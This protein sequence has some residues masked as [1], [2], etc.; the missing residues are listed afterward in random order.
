MRMSSG[1]A[2]GAGMPVDSIITD[3]NHGKQDSIMFQKQPKTVASTIT[4]MGTGDCNLSYE[5]GG[6]IK[7]SVGVTFVDQAQTKKSVI[8]GQVNEY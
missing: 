6:K 2:K 8:T 4:G 5:G 3:N 7:H 1:R